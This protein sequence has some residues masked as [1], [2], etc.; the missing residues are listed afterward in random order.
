MPKLFKTISFYLIAILVGFTAVYATSKLTPPGSVTNTM[1]SLTDI[2][3]LSAGTTTSEGTGII[4]TTP[5]TIA[6]TGKT[7][8]EVYIA[9]ST[10]IAKLSSI[11]I[12]SGTTAFGITGSTS[13]INTGDATATIGDIISPKTAYVNGVKLTGIA[14]AGGLPKTGQITEYQSGDDG[15]YQ[16]GVSVSPSFTDNTDG[17][18]LDNSTG[19]MWKKCSEGQSGGDCLGGSAT[20]KTWTQ[21]LTTCEADTTAS[22]TDWRLPNIRELNSIVRYN[23]VNPCIDQTSFPNTQ[24]SSYWSSTT[25]ANSSTNALTTAFST[26]GASSPFNKVN[27]DYV[28]CVRGG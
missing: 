28:R 9:I 6:E 5:G 10:E 3:N 15:T 23:V 27:P 21:A 8:T 20:T 1:Y 25:Y 18:V 7:L 22:F 14:S 24:T 19:L 4:E 2:Y 11:K 12:T 13:V 17:T 26:V 16:K